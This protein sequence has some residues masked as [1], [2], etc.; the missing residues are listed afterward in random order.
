MDTK[1]ITATHYYGGNNSSY[2]KVEMIIDFTNELFHLKIYNGYDSVDSQ[3]YHCTNSLKSLIPLKY[4][5]NFIDAKYSTNI[6]YHI[7]ENRDTIIKGT[8][9][10]I[11]GCFDKA[12]VELEEVMVPYVNKCVKTFTVV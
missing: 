11:A 4:G 12:F 2:S 10:Y 5:Y 1:T 8:S 6:E 7:G 9:S 3:I